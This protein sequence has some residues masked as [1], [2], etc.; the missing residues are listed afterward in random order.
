MVDEQ[1]LKLVCEEGSEAALYLLIES[2]GGYTFYTNHELADG[3]LPEDPEIHKELAQ[4]QKEI[5]FAVDHT[6]RFGVTTPRNDKGI[7]GEDYWKWFR[8]WDAYAKG[9]SDA[10]Y[11]KFDVAVQKAT[12]AQKAL[13]KWR[14]KGDW[15]PKPTEQQLTVVATDLAEAPASND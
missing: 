15:R 12:E 6:T 2:I 14:P 13:K 4:A 8:W 10:D 11:R 1:F 9:L 7:A 3:R 5:E